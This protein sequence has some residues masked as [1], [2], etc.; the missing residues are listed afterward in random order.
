MCAFIREGISQSP[1]PT[2]GNLTLF[3]FSGKELD[4]ETGL[5]YYGAR[6]LNPRTSMWISADP[7]LGEYV[8]QAGKGSDGLPGFGGVYNAINKHVYAYTHN[9]P[10]KYV[11]PDGREPNRAQAAVVS[12]FVNSMNTSENKVGLQRGA[13]A[14]VALQ[15][16]SNTEGLIPKPT[17]TP[18]FN[19]KVGRYIY[20]T[21]GGWIDMVHF[22]FYAGDARKQ[23]VS[24]SDSPVQD[25]VMYGVQQ[26]SFDFLFAPH[27]AFS[28][29]D[30]TSDKYGAIFGADVF[31]PNSDKTLAEQIQDYLV[32]DLGATTPLRA[33]NWKQLP[34][35]D[36]RSPPTARN[37]ST[38]PMYTIE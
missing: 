32:N 22:L 4:T 12:F 23:K 28:Y 18:Y 16:F 35:K 30:L 26:E 15:S 5:Y 25:A 13:A 20:T 17:V 9:N 19:N 1:I 33:P 21:K 31:D 37:F 36:S 24:G 27:S 8:P 7:A 2:G 11:D 34:P 10:L 14:D 3:S 6:Y 29:E 38:V